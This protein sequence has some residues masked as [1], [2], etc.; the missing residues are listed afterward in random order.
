[1]NQQTNVPETKTPA[2]DPSGA[3]ARGLEAALGGALE[4]LFTIGRT[5][6]AHGLEIGQQALRTSARTLEITAKTLG[7]VATRLGKPAAEEA[8]PADEKQEPAQN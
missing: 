5:W 7:E 1:M 4:G 3:H 6:A 8:P 2:T